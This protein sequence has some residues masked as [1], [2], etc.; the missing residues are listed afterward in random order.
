MGHRT[1]LSYSLD[2]WLKSV[3]HNVTSIK[4]FVPDRYHIYNIIYN[5]EKR[6]IHVLH[7][8]A[9]LNLLIGN[10]LENY[11]NNVTAFL[12]VEG[13]RQPFSPYVTGKSFSSPPKKY[14]KGE[15]KRAESISMKLVPR[16][17]KWSVYN[18]ARSNLRILQR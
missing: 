14:I 11:R 15:K 7:F 18:L 9:P 12:Q 6:L 1:C 3:I 8:V 16:L 2:V 13:L 4:I 5:N 17:E 10:R